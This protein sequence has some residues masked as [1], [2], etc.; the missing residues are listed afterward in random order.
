MSVMVALVDRRALL[1][2]KGIAAVLPSIA[3]RSVFFR[4][5]RQ[6]RSHPEPPHLAPVVRRRK[7][8]YC[9]TQNGTTHPLCGRVG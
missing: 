9:L 1:G 8:A 7:M 5:A 3:R 4:R 2:T 6:F